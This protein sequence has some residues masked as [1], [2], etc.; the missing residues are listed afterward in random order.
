V[1]VVVKPGLLSAMD[2]TKVL[3]NTR[4]NTSIFSIDMVSLM[5][6]GVDQLVVGQI[7]QSSATAGFAHISF[8]LEPGLLA[9]LPV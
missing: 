2:G 9:G 6:R 7:W 4:V 8:G 3:K 1:E 5:E